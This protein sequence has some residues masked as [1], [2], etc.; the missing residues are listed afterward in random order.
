VAYV[1]C[2]SSASTQCFLVACSGM[3]SVISRKCPPTIT[4]RSPVTA[5]VISRKSG[6][7]PE[8]NI[9]WK[10]WGLTQRGEVADTTHYSC[11]FTFE[12]NAIRWRALLLLIIRKCPRVQHHIPL[13]PVLGLLAELIEVPI[14][15][16]RMRTH[17][18]HQSS[19]SSHRP[20]VSLSVIVP[21][22]HGREY[23][24]RRC[25]RHRQGLLFSLSMLTLTLI[26]T[27]GAMT[28]RGCEIERISLI[29]ICRC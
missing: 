3:R 13:L 7:W 21:L 29:V 9:K 18:S 2:A 10:G 26:N 14:V 6:I 15:M 24:A 16:G 23:N 19:V 27:V 1:I 12:T 8:S 22:H 25:C 28:G 20:S 4:T 5:T 17:V 11:L